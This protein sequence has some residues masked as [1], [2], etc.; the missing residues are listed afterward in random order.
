MKPNQFI[1]VKSVSKGD[2]EKFFTTAEIRAF[3]RQHLGYG[4]NPFIRWASEPDVAFVDEQETALASMLQQGDGRPVSYYEIQGIRWLRITSH[5]EPSVQ[6]IMTEIEG[7]L[8]V[9]MVS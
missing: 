4:S 1:P 7:N 2:V 8:L 9:T 3:L 5:Y 6:G